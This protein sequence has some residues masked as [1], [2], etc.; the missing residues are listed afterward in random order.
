[1]YYFF[2]SLLEPF[3][4]LLLLMGLAIASLWG[5]R[6]KSRRRLLLLTVLFLLLV[7]FSIP[8]VSYLA[9]GSLEWQY[10]PLKQRPDSTK[11][12][13][14]LSAAIYPPDDV[15]P[16]TVLSESTLYRCLHAV[17][18]Y[19]QGKPCPVVLS[20]GKVDPAREGPT[21]AA[22][23]R[24]FMLQQGIAEEDLLLEDR[25]RTTY[26]NA[27]ESAKLLEERAIGEIVLVTDAAS[28][29]RA[30]RCFLRQGLKVTAAGCHYRATKL[31]GFFSDFWPHPG[32]A[33]KTQQACHEWIGIVWYWL[34]GRI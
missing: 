6:R 20:G 25:S 10:P 1:M 29:Y 17:E 2:V 16:R 11:A 33:E 12:I 4:L 18:L 14:V 26:E 34:H 9:L 28:L 19:R 22:A 23:M 21:L 15:R 32:A 5:K 8:A 30:R 13:V 31:E 27:V 7:T 24:D 3:P